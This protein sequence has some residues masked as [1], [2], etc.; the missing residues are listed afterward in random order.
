MLSTLSWLGFMPDE[1]LLAPTAAL[2]RLS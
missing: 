1:V 2:G